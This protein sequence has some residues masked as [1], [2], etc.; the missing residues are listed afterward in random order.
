MSTPRQHYLAGFLAG[1]GGSR[2]DDGSAAALPPGTAERDASGAPATRSEPAPLS[3]EEQV[4]QALSPFDAF[5]RLLACAEADQPPAEADRFRF[6]WFGLFYQGPGSDAFVLR[7]R[8]PGGRLRGFQWLGLTE[9]VQELARGVV[10][11]NACGGLDLPGIPVRAGAEVLR[12]VEALGLSP[13]GTGGDCVR[14]V[15]GAE[16]EGCLRAEPPLVYGLVCA[17]EQVLA[18]SREFGDL[19]GPCEV[20]FRAA[21]GGGAADGERARIIFRVSGPAASAPVTPEGWPREKAADAPTWQVLLPG[22]GEL[23]VALTRADIVPTCL[24]LLRVWSRR[25]ERIRREQAALEKFCAGLGTAK[26]RAALEQELGKS[27]VS[28]SGSAASAAVEEEALLLLEVPGGRLSSAQMVSL[29]RLVARCGVDELRLVRP[30]CLLVP[31]GAEAAAF[32]AILRRTLV[33]EVSG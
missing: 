23:G 16:R 10:E 5:P 2:P 11:W 17:L 25:A 28:S 14:A 30:G 29:A 9:V 8:L 19:P 13:R 6:Q 33:P 24:A 27:L 1:R 26:L 32:E 3:W 12:R 22:S 7:V 15:R 20:E 4:K 21:D 31:G 18:Q